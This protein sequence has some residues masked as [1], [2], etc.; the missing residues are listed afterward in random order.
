MQEPGF[1]PWTLYLFTLWVDFQA[2]RLPHKKKKK[3]LY[4]QI[5]FFQHIINKYSNTSNKNHQHRTL[6]KVF[7][8]RLNETLDLFDDFKT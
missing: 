7:G 2:N 1:D 6:L 5:F 3:Y 4:V 8:K